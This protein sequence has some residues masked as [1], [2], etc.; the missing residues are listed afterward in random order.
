MADIRNNMGHEQLCYEKY[1]FKKHRKPNTSGQQRWRCQKEN[2]KCR[3][4]VSTTLDVNGIIMM[5]IL[6]AE[7][8]HG[9]SSTD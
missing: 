4:A 2:Q 1:L 8:N 3:A 6:C 9:P 5:K 7:H